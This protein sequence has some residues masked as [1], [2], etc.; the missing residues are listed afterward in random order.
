[1]TL[2]GWSFAFGQ[3]V[4]DS[5]EKAS[6]TIY[7]VMSLVEM[8]EGDDAAEKKIAQMMFT[9]KKSDN[10]QGIRRT[11]MDAKDYE[12]A[13]NRLARDGW[14]LVTVTKSNYWVWK[15]IK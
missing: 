2:V 15:K 6:A 3:A 9:V 5:Q 8:F 4:P 10:T 14:T 7:R 12:R 11:E 13:L 1:M